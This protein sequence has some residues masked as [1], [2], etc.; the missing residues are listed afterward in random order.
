MNPVFAPDERLVEWRGWPP[1]FK[2]L[3]EWVWPTDFRKFM[4]WCFAV[5]SLGFLALIP[6]RLSHAHNAPILWNLLVGAVFT[7]HMAA[8]TGIA[9]WTIWKA[10]PWARGWAIAASL[11]Y[12][13][14]FIR[15]FIVPMREVW[16]HNLIAL[17]L[18]LLGLASFAWPDRNHSLSDVQST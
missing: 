17:S 1:T 10:Q 13:V 11:M 5:T 16:D 4:F 18:G 12:I 3:A 6:Y 8:L 9:A 7:V 2:P 14:V 15:P